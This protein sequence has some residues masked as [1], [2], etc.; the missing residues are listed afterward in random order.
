MQNLI[1]CFLRDFKKHFKK[2]KQRTII[3]KK[4]KN[5]NHKVLFYQFYFLYALALRFYIGRILQNDIICIF[6]KMS[7]EIVV[8]YFYEIKYSAVLFSAES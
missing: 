1:K 6:C 5:N 3:S 8:I 2:S 4:K 7:T